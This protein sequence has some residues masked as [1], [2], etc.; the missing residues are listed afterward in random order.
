MLQF[1]RKHIFVYN[2]YNSSISESEI[3]ILYLIS[4]LFTKTK[5]HKSAQNIS[6]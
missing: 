3:K 4:S 1:H 6:K 5:L 2:L